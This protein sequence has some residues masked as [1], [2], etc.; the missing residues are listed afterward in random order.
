MSSGIGSEGGARQGGGAS[1]D[2]TPEAHAHGGEAAGRGRAY[3][4]LIIG[5]GIG[6]LVCGGILAKEGLRVCVLEKNPQIGGALQT[7]AR[8]KVLFDAGVHYMG[9][10]APGQNLY[11]IFRYLGIME[12]LKL[13]KMDEE[14]FDKILIGGDPKEYT[15]AQGY[16]RFVEALAK[17]FPNEEKGIRAYT[18]LIREVCGRFPLY[19]LRAGGVYAEKTGVL[20]MDTKATI[21]A[22]V[23][24]PVL[25]EV[26][27]GNNLLYAGQPDKTPFY[28]HALVLNSFIESSWKCTDGGGQLAKLLANV[29]RERNGEIKTRAEVTHII[30]GGAQVEGVQL[31]DGTTLKSN[32]VVSSLH[33]AQTMQLTPAAAIKPAFRNRVESLENSISCFCVNLVLKPQRVHYVKHNYYYHNKGCA[34]TMDDYTEEDWPRGYALFFAQNR[35]QSGYA[36]S[37]TLMT[38]MRY[39]DTT[40]WADTRN[41][42]AEA[43]ERGQAYEAFKQDR[44][45]RLMGRVTEKFPELREAVDHWYASTPLTFRDYLGTSDGSLYGIA[46]DYR[47][48][49][50]TIIPARTKVGGLFLTGQNL[51]LHGI[52]GAAISSLATCAEVLGRDDFVGKIKSA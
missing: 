44:Y 26:L 10:L 5:S 47:D 28:V 49:V 7:Y 29:I 37:V 51:N 14:A 36:S 31:K 1:G 46:K 32:I 25:R 17:D 19:N 52:L 4:A 35:N 12:E 27:A 9:G 39:A 23:R 11:Q 38:Y 15:F 24:D 3:D 50:R 48:P 16:E 33:P 18:D 30:A 20:D 6:G 22:C 8:N 43:T 34:W 2:G 13:A 45:Q 21:E 40:P 42:V 41:T